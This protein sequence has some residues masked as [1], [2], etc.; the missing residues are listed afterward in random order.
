MPSTSCCSVRRISGRLHDLAEGD[1]GQQPAGGGEPDPTQGLAGAQV[2]EHLVGGGGQHQHPVGPLDA[3]RV[4]HRSVVEPRGG[5]L[6]GRLGHPVVTAAAQSS[7]SCSSP[8]P[9]SLACNARARSTSSSSRC[10]CWGSTTG[11]TRQPSRDPIDAK[12]SRRCSG[13]GH[14]V[15]R[16]R[17]VPRAAM[18]SRS[19]ALSSRSRGASVVRD[20]V[21]HPH[22]GLQGDP[23]QQ[24]RTRTLRQPLHGARRPS[25]R[26]A[27]CRWCRAAPQLII[28]LRP[29]G[30]DAVSGA[31]DRRTARRW[32]RPPARA[33]AGCCA[34]WVRGRSA[35]AAAGPAGRARLVPAPRAARQGPHHVAAAHHP[36]QLPVRVHDRQD[37]HGHRGQ[38]VGGRGQVG[39][40]ADA[41]GAGA[42]TSARVPAPVRPCGRSPCGTRPLMTSASLSTPSSLPASST[43]GSEVMPW[44]TRTASTSA[45][46]RR[47]GW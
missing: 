16:R 20:L 42:I 24:R 37:R 38:Q 44:R 40:G 18:A 29:S 4:D 14:D 31:R 7:A 6:E 3:A 39:L 46:R 5:A 47:R 45:T 10:R 11:T 13:T 9:G 12:R 28:M 21:V 32:A 41:D 17:S 15:N 1:Q 27:T 25:P 23:R 35:R 19:R 8:S 34:R 33:R 43:T 30:S 26:A 2:V 22:R 36:D